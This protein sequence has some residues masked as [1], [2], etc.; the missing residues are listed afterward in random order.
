MAR[1]QHSSDTSFIMSN[2]HIGLTIITSTL[3]TI[4]RVA[5]SGGYRH[6]VHLR[7]TQRLMTENSPQKWLWVKR[8]SDTS[9]IMFNA[10]IGLTI[11]PF[12]IFIIIRVAWQS[13]E[14]KGFLYKVGKK[15]LSHHEKTSTLSRNSNRS[16]AFSP[17]RY[18]P[19]IVE[20][21]F[22]WWMECY[23]MTRNI[24]REE[25]HSDAKREVACFWLVANRQQ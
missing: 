13:L 22:Q 12:T 6:L 18:T 1:V 25:G 2:A 14:E 10:H 7:C 20:K 21:H 17:L 8:S 24:L 16:K 19:P 9:F 5:I 11:I 15:R 4:I 3:L 23:W